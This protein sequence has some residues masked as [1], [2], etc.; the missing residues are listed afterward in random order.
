MSAVAE[1]TRLR[2]HCRNPHCRS[3]LKQPIENKHH[4]FCVRGCYDSFYLHRCRVCERD[5]RSRQGGRLYCRPPEKCRS[6]ASKWPDQ[7]KWRPQPAKSTTDPSCA[8]STGI[9]FGLSGHR[10]RHHRLRHWWSGDPVDG[11]LSLYDENGLTLARLVLEDGAYR[12]RTPVTWPRLSW[13]RIGRAA[14]TML[15]V[16]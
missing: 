2:H 8:D 4:A 11:D 9:K 7:Y 1:T 10:P 14:T 16:E 3:K 6:E 12:L 13:Q 5:L 15:V